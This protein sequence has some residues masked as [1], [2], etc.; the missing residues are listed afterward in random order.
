MWRSFENTFGDSPSFF[1]STFRFRLFGQR[2]KIYYHCLSTSVV[3]PQEEAK[4]VCP[5]HFL[6]NYGDVVNFSFVDPFR[7]DKEDFLKLLQRKFG[8][9]RDKNG[10]ETILMK[11]LC[12]KIDTNRMIST[13]NFYPSLR[14][15]Y[16]YFSL[17]FFF[18]II[19]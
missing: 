5:F 1:G 10:A 16:L 8:E 12:V 7:L 4:I 13:D 2:E 15:I 9:K 11:N 17:S 3:D 6:C 19:K 14:I 18:F